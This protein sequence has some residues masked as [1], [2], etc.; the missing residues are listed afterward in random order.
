MWVREAAGQ[1]CVVGM[2]EQACEGGEEWAVR[3]GTW[4]VQRSDGDLT[5][6]R[7]ADCDA[8]EVCMSI[9]VFLSRFHMYIYIYICMYIYTYIYTCVYVCTSSMSVYRYFGSAHMC[10]QIL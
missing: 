3:R 10:L 8:L 9:S 1:V 4:H 5:P 7:H 6:L 2:Y